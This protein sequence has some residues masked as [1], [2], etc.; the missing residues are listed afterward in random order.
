[1]SEGWRHP[2]VPAAQARLADRELVSWRAGG[3][4]GPF[5]AAAMMLRSLWHHDPAAHTFLEVGCGAGYYSEIIAEEFPTAV[6]TGCDYA[7]GMVAEASTRYPRLKFSCADQRF[8]LGFHTASID[9]VWNGAAL[10]HLMT[11]EDWQQAITEAARVSRRWL[12]FHRVPVRMNCLPSQTHENDFYDRAAPTKIPERYVAR[13]EWDALLAP[14]R[15]VAIE[16]WSS[17]DADPQWE[18]VLVEKV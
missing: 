17:V 14:F 10:L 9:C 1:M 12:V 13:D 5:D 6:Y 15:R 4:H 3:E 11:P 2:A 18:S 7:P 8:L 16:S